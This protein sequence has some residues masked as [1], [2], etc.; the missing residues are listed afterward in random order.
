MSFLTGFATG[1]AKSVDA[2]LKE[3]I[4]RTRDNIDMVSKW[5]L[6]KAE[7]R[8]KERR[9]K[10][11]EI[12]T[13]IK[14]AAFVIGGDQN[15]LDA[16]NI[17]AALYKERGLSGF[18]SDI[19][20]MRNQ[21][22]SGV[23]VRPLDFINRA[24]VDVPEN[25]FKLSE[26]VRSLS[27][28]ES[29]FAPSDMI[30]PK[31]TIKPS[32][33]IGA[34][35]PGFDVMAAGET[36]ATQQMQ[37]IGMD[38]VPTA[39]SL[40]FTK[41]KFDRE[42]MNYHSMDTNSKLNYL[43]DIIVNPASSEDDVQKAQ[44]R[45]EALL[46]LAM[47]Q[48]D[49]K[50]ALKA[51]EQS[52]SQ[53]NPE[54]AGYSDLITN[55]REISDKIKLQEAELE[56]KEAVLRAQAE[57]AARDGNT[58]L[59][60]K[61]SRDADDLA[62]GGF[63]PLKTQIDRIN[64][65]IQR[66]IARHGDAYRNSEGP[67]QGKGLAEDEATRNALMTELS[68]LNETSQAS[69]NQA[70]KNIF[71]EAKYNLSID[72]PGL[73]AALEKLA[74]SKGDSGGF[75]ASDVG[76]IL[77]LL[78]EQGADAPAKFREAIKSAA[79]VYMEQAKKQGWNTKSISLALERFNGMD[80]DAM[81]TSDTTGDTGVASDAAVAGQT[82]EAL[83]KV[84]T[85]ADDV[86]AG[87][88][89]ISDADIKKLVES[90]GKLD[91]STMS[92]LRADYPDTIRGAL[93]FIDNED[94]KSYKDKDNNVIPAATANEIIAESVGLHGENFTNNVRNILDPQNKI[95]ATTALDSAGAFKQ[96][97]VGIVIDKNAR[98][99]AV[100]TLV[101]ENPTLS[102][103]VAN[104]IVNKVV[105]ERLEV[106]TENLKKNIPLVKDALD[107][108]NFL[109]NITGQLIPYRRDKAIEYVATMLN[110]SPE[111]ADML[112]Q[113]A[114]APADDISAF[115]VEAFDIPTGTSQRDESSPEERDARIAAASKEISDNPIARTLK[116]DRPLVGEDGL[117][118]DVGDVNLSNALTDFSKQ[119]NDGNKRESL[120]SKPQKRSGV[121]SIAL[122]MKYVD[123][124]LTA[125][126]AK[127]LRK[128]VEGPDG[129][130]IAMA[131]QR[132][133][134]KRKA[135]KEVSAYTDA[136]MAAQPPAPKDSLSQSQVKALKQRTSKQRMA[137]GG[138]MGR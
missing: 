31:G 37:E 12:E 49:D 2:Q 18:T 65:D 41:Y 80:F 23:G 87:A 110:V 20:F 131:I 72:N 104:H 69:V 70:F 53:M 19:E 52:L 116:G 33:M 68:N 35:V 42:G 4:E 26:I 74:I 25:R 6:K 39:P 58:E 128:R 30:F 123:G 43:Q 75:D 92:V 61:L 77:K 57:I 7:E 126:E 36:R 55:R 27:D 10:D 122:A 125:K 134:E 17:A 40:D 101:Q 66:N 100:Q 98:E 138:L 5:R 32:G 1:F 121:S 137:R 120:V 64:I 8:E 96:G 63:T 86:S 21:V 79:S 82:D 115:D 107:R 113:R 60:T 73:A 16:Q 11:Q 135:E 22:E 102:L 117:L 54:D 109:S 76:A 88:G 85:G 59:A 50:T 45:R 24:S 136:D 127:E 97:E 111:N 94:F 81:T 78:D 15:N 90:K 29:S 48:G 89:D 103:E 46:N 9:K 118:L 84:S 14:D 34:I 124:T 71:S 51:I 133:R 62:A 129:A 130:D 38:A 47:E 93:D 91:E 108:K 132:I 95:K 56:G 67:F 13:L 119:S 3:S 44:K 105:Q 114:I 106:E 112:I 28:A 99:S 83:G